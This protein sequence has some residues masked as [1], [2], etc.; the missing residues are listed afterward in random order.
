[1][2]LTELRRSSSG[3]TSNRV[4]STSY[5][6]GFLGVELLAEGV[7]DPRLVIGLD[8]GLALRRCGGDS[9]K[10]VSLVTLKRFI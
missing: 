8:P 9:A 6:R 7:S 3:R 1:M 2:R 10:M 5:F 4:A